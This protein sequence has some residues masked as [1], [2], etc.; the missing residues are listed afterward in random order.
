MEHGLTFFMLG[1][2]VAQMKGAWFENQHD[3]VA[4]LYQ[5]EESIRV[6][7]ELAAGLGRRGEDLTA[8]HK[9]VSMI[10]QGGG[11]ESQEQAAHTARHLS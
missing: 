1:I 5:V 4:A 6:W 11:G 2:M 7:L 8:M 10:A 3:L 9:A